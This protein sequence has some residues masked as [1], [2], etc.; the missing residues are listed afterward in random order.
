MRLISCIN[1]LTNTSILYCVLL[2][3]NDHINHIQYANIVELAIKQ[4][5]NL[6]TENF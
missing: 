3:A 5:I 2:S 4:F 6:L 1:E